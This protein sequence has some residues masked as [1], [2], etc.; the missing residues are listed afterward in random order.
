MCQELRQHFTYTDWIVQISC[1]LHNV[2]LLCYF[3]TL[4]RRNSSNV[5]HLAS[6]VRGPE[7]QVTGFRIY[8]FNPGSC[9]CSSLRRAVVFHQNRDVS[10]YLSRDGPD[11]QSSGGKR[12]PFVLPGRSFGQLLLSWLPLS[13]KY[14]HLFLNVLTPQYFVPMEDLCY[15]CWFRMCWSGCRERSQGIIVVPIFPERPRST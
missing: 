3:H 14:G 5:I 6:G 12:V 15:I 13:I 8:D 7:P 4:L 11:S 2:K 10:T 1:Q 9:P